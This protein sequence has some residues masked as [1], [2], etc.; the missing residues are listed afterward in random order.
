MKKGP[1]FALPAAVFLR[2]YPKIREALK[3]R[4]EIYNKTI[5]R[6]RE[7]EKQGIIKVAA[8]KSLPGSVFEKSSAKLA[9]IYDIGYKEGG[10]FFLSNRHE[11]AKW[12]R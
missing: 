12:T 3:N 1:S 6:M 5:D 8:P 10:L 2:K 7:L 9:E 4:A 11:F